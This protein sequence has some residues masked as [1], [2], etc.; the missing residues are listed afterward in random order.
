VTDR[1]AGNPSRERILDAAAQVMRD[2]GLANA[3]TK[4]IAAAAGYSEAML[5]KHFAD[6]QELFL[7]VLEERTPSV[8]IDVASAGHGDLTQNLAD[9]VEQLMSFFTQTFPIAAS[10]FG[11]PE[12]LAQHRHGV[13]SHGRGPSGPLL[14]VQSYLDAERAAGRI[15]AD[16]DTATAARLLV[17][18]AFHQGFLAAFEGLDDVPDAAPKAAGIAMAVCGGTADPLSPARARQAGP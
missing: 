11:A 16:A 10:V 17:G 3:T 9:L 13:T 6:K 7:A 18:A 8:R 12:L 2:K 4:L 5:Y 15:A 14:A 1:P